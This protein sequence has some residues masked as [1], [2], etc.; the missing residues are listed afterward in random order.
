MST[1]KD[2]I[3]QEAE[4]AKETRAAVFSIWAG[5]ALDRRG[6]TTITLPDGRQLARNGWRRFVLDGEPTDAETLAAD[7]VI[8]DAVAAAGKKAN[9]ENAQ[10]LVGRLRDGLAAQINVINTLR[11]ALANA[12]EVL[13]KFDGKVFNVRFKNAVEAM[14]E[15]VKQV[16]GRNAPAYRLSASEWTRSRLT[17]NAVERGYRSGDNWIYLDNISCDFDVA[18]DGYNRIDAAKTRES[19]EGAMKSLDLQAADAEDAVKNIRATLEEVEKTAA[20]VEKM[21]GT[22]KTDGRWRYFHAV[23][24][25]SVDNVIRLFGQDFRWAELLSALRTIEKGGEI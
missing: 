23:P 17:V 3:R 24:K 19:V 15:N 9:L 16:N 14:A 20:A 12:L 5:I 22:R 4:E 2:N 18:V 7:D 10:W 1:E 13:P 25:G 21:N 11:A 6:E 8:Y